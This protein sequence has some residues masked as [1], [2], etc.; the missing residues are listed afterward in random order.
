MMQGAEMYIDLLIKC[1]SNTIY[2][3]ANRG[4]WRPREYDADA[5]RQGADWPEL[6]HSMIG[7]LRLENIRD[8]MKIVLRELIPG[9]LI[10]AGV[11]RGGACIL[12]RGILKAYNERARTVYVADSF[13]GLPPPD[14]E[15]YPADS[16]QIIH[17]F[18]YMAVSRQTVEANFRAYDLFD[19]QVAFVEGWFKDTL[20]HLEA[21]KFAL[22]RLDGDLY[23][24]TIQSLESLYPKL[25]VGGFVLVDDYGS[26]PSC[27]QAVHDYRTAQRIS[28][29]IIRVDTSGIYWRRSQPP[30]SEKLSHG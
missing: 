14:P 5:R 30:V 15:H 19:E 8:L 6:A 16:G 24:S 2:G 18:D 23:E 12:M 26:W 9:D 29:P 25:S 7:I 13:Q 17:T 1:I 3:D 27:R 28:D 21:Q 10:E 20:P 22:I 4:D 11:W